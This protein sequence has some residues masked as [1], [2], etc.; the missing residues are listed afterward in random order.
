MCLYFC[1]CG[2]FIFPPVSGMNTCNECEPGILSREAEALA[3]Q[4]KQVIR[5]RES[6][7]RETLNNLKRKYGL[8]R[9]SFVDI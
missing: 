9:V 6:N 5:S 7:R 2:A 4:T 3:S 1:F 8:E